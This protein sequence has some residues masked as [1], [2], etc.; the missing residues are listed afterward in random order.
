LIAAQQIVIN[1]MIDVSGGI[2]NSWAPTRASGG[3]IRLVAESVTG[4]GPQGLAQNLIA[5]PDGRIRIEGSLSSNLL[6]VPETIGVPPANPPIIW[7]AANAP[8]ARVLSVDNTP[9]KDPLDP[10][11]PLIAAA[12]IA[13]QNNAPVNILIETRDFPI[14]GVVQLA[15]IPKFGG[16]SWLTA[17]RISGDINLATW[18]VTTTLPQG[19]VTLQARATQP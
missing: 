5:I 19:F 14:E 18:R 15:V 2:A 11:A 10:R 8:K 16:R 6:T 17:T 9:P 1:G 4:T 3:A 7:P 12:D 13:I